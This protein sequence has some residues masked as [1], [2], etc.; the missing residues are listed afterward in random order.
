MAK[1]RK[2]E[3]QESKKASSCGGLGC[4][5][6][7]LI[8]IAAGVVAYPYY[9]DYLNLPG[10]T[11]T[12]PAKPPTEKPPS[13]LVLEQFDCLPVYY[14]NGD[15]QFFVPIHLPIESENEP[16][17]IRAKKILDKIVAGPPVDGLMKTIPAGTKIN[18]VKT[19]GDLVIVDLSGD[20]TSYGGGSTWERGIVRSIVLS[21]TELPGIRRVQ[22][23]VD[24]KQMEYLPQGTII[25]KPMS[26]KR[27][28]NSNEYLPEG[29]T[30]GYL[31]YLE[32]TGRYIVP[33]YWAWDGDKADVVAK[34]KT[35][36]SPPVPPLSNSLISPAPS[37]IRIE[38]CEIKRNKLTLI[39]DHHDFASAFHNL[40]A[41]KFLKA[42][43]LT[44]HQ[45]QSFTKIDIR[46]GDETNNR[47][48]WTYSTFADLQDIEIPP[49]CYNTLDVSMTPTV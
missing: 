4:F 6:F 24:G 28:P 48:I 37:G 3:Y 9:K 8:I 46:V 16:I 31:Y 45:F 20:I 10:I 47:P 18:S 30:S 41:M 43:L 27:G 23:L 12:P 11:I 40:S 42:T 36:Y 2:P 33:V 7:I 19:D 1:S 26:R 17:D 21:L 13:E 38:K 5:L 34:L 29:K 35:L 32:R 39:I 49:K 15:A 44:L 25:S 22:F 14:Y